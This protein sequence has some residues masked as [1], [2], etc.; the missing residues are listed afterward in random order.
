MQCCGFVFCCSVLLKQSL[1]QAHSGLIS[2]H[3][4][5]L[6][7]HTHTPK[8]RLNAF[9]IRKERVQMDCTTLWRKV[10]TRVN[11]GQ[12]AHPEVFSAGCAELNVVST[13]VVDTGLG[14][15]GIVLNLRFPGQGRKRKKCQLKFQNTG[16][17]CFK[18]PKKVPKLNPNNQSVT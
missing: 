2:L 8:N 13:V 9:G 11:D 17:P 12:C 18:N 14:Q 15:H 1:G 5:C 10:L 7:T 6:Y 16:Q 4:L 3:Q